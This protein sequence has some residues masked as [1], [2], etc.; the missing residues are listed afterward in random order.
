MWSVPWDDPDNPVLVPIPSDSLYRSRWPTNGLLGRF[1]PYDR[2]DSALTSE[3]SI[4]RIDRRI[5]HY[6]HF[7]PL[8][9]PYLVEW[10]GQLLAPVDGTY[11]LGIQAVSSAV[12]DIDGQR[13]LQS[14]SPGQYTDTEQHMNSG[15]HDILIR[16][17]DNQDRSQIY[18]YWQ[19]PGNEDVELVP[20]EALFLPPD[21]AWWD[22]P[23]SEGE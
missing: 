8:P 21:G 14:E 13:V 22:V 23:G 2:L 11:R 12:L 6:F 16:F 7:L 3:P 17:L 4:A 19:I 20:P 9:R 1:Y 18:L 15:P 10:R 5:A